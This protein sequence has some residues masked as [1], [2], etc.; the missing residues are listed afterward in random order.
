VYRQLANKE[1]E[2]IPVV[3]P[4]NKKLS[5]ANSLAQKS[6][7]GRGGMLTKIKMAR[8][9]ADLGITTFIVN[10]QTPNILLDILSGETLGTKFLSRQ[11]PSGVKKWVAS[12]TGQ[13]KGELY[14]NQGA[15]EMLTSPKVASLLPIGVVRIE[16]SFSKGDIVR[17]KN[18]RG[19][20][21]G[22]GV[23]QYGADQAKKVLGKKGSKPLVHYDYLFLEL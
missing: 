4:D 3:K 6:K 11:K 14:I 21:I 16:G 13:E 10:G 19:Q 22:V 15:V 12:S 5:L 23:A 1:S 20:N 2:I 18:Q 9:A 17:I 8:R 7:F